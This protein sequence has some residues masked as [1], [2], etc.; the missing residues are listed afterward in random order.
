MMDPDT[1]KMILTD[2]EKLRRI[3]ATFLVGGH[4]EFRKP[5]NG[6]CSVISLIENSEAERLK[7]EAQR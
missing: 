4:E 6:I 2:L 3:I 1:K 7:I 5:Y